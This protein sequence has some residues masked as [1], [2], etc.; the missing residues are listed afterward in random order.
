[1][2]QIIKQ[3]K[4]QVHELFQENHKNKY[5]NPEWIF[6]NHI[7]PMIEICNELCEKH[8][9]NKEI[10][11]L[12]C[13]LHDTGLVYKR[14]QE[15]PVGHEE[16][17]VEYACKIFEEFFID[18]QMKED[19]INCIIATECKGEVD[20]INERIVRTADNLSKFITPHFFAKACFSGNWEDYSEWLK[21]KV[22][23]SYA[24]ICF[25]EEQEE[26]REVKNWILSILK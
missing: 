26:I 17:S 16:R 11:E 25:K 14:T 10:C 23:K 2:Q 9:G 7:D 18:K 22:S 24:N 13:I 8:N 5:Q 21:N 19:I 3:I 12:A 6:P 20:N 4:E 15:S 1:M